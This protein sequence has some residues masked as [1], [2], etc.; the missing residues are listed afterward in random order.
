MPGRPGGP[1]TVSPND[2]FAGAIG[3]AGAKAGA[4]AAAAPAAGAAYPRKA[5]AAESSLVAIDISSKSD[6]L[7]SH[8]T[9]PIAITDNI[10]TDKVPS[11]MSRIIVHPP[12]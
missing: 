9:N 12:D 8:A 3:G 5:S 10:R 11:F 4:G 1:D 2:C 7:L 6:D